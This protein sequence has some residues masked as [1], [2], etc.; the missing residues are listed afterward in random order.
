MTQKGTLHSFGLLFII[1]NGY[2][3]PTEDPTEIIA[4][5]ACLCFLLFN[6]IFFPYFPAQ[7]PY[8]A[9]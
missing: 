8:Y 2:H 9:Q 5:N 1:M 7:K 4:G 3:F 6:I